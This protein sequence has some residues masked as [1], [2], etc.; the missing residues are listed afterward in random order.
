MSQSFDTRSQPLADRLAY[1]SDV[2]S[3]QAMPVTLDVRDNVAVAAGLTSATLGMAQ[4]IDGF[5]GNHIYERRSAEIKISDPD[6]IGLILPA[7]GSPIVEQDGRQTVVPNGGMSLLDSSRPCQ[8]VF[9]E[10]FR[11][12]VI[13]IPKSAL[14]LSNTQLQN[15]TAV[16]L[17]HDSAVGRVVHG[18]LRQVISHS[19]TLEDDSESEAI[20]SHAI[21][22]I[23]TLI[24]SVFAHEI[25]VTG[26]TAVLR[27]RVMVFLHRHHA[28]PL[29]TPAMIAVAHHV[30]VRSLHGAFADAAGSLMD[31]LRA[32]RIEY[33]RKDL[34]NPYFH[35]LQVAQIAHAHGFQTPSDFSRTFRST[36]GASPS[37]YRES[38]H[39][40]TTKP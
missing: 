16:S 14:R 22:L 15:I 25:A 21:S 17:P 33:A 34:I 30:S 3:L 18:A 37:E 5:G 6:G 12:Q 24:R 27:E 31:T 40:P 35:H 11:W 8:I 36:V 19:S 26:K 32:L 13:A 2:V 4:M 7:A 28:D 9:Q 20:G 29:L 38:G 23:A 10:S 39:A 1:W